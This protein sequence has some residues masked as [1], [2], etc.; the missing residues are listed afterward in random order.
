QHHARQRLPRTAARAADDRSPSAVAHPRAERMA[1]S[2][3]RGASSSLSRLLQRDGRRARDAAP[4]A[5]RGRF[6]SERQGLRHHGAA[7]RSGSSAR[8][9][10]V[11]VIR[12][13]GLSREYGA[14]PALQNLDLRVEPGEILNTEPCCPSLAPS[15]CWVT[16]SPRVNP[17]L[18]SQ[19][20]LS[21]S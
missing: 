14:K 21:G 8:A 13:E 5:Q 12:T 16:G 2:V 7:R 4:G 6:A 17:N 18:W 19:M 10:A 9:A 20:I 11:V 3:R 15:R 1:E